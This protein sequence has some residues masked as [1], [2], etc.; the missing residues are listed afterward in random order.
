M[1]I[2]TTTL[3]RVATGMVACAFSLHAQAATCVIDAAANRQTIDGFGFSSAWSGTLSTAKNDALY[4]TL[5]FSLLRIRIDPNQNWSEETANSSAAHARGAKVMGSSWTPPASMK[6]NN[7]LVGGHLRTDQYGAYASWLNQAANSI[8]LDYVSFQNEPD[9]TVTY[10]S[11]SWTAA[12]LQTFVRNNA[13]TIG[14]SVIMPES[15][16]FNDA[17]SDPTLNDSVAVNNVAVVGG[18]IYGNGLFVH[19]NAINKGK[20]VWMTEHYIDNTQSSMANC[21]TIAKE[22][23]DCMN[24]QM[25]AYYWWWVTDSDTSIN[26]VNSSG[27][28]FKN[29]YTLGQFAKWIRPGSVRVAADYNPTSGIYVTAYKSNNN[30]IIVAINTSTGAV[31][32]QFS[33]SNGSVG[34]VT[35]YR[36]SSSQNLAQLG[37]IALSGN[38]FT[39]SLPGQSVT[40]FVQASTGGSGPV[41]DGTYKIVARHSGL[42][43]EVQGA[44]TANGSQIDQYTYFGNNHQRWTVTNRGNNQYSLIGVASGRGIDIANASTA[45]G[46]KVQLYD[47]WG[48]N[49]QKFTFTATSN[50]YYRITPVHATSSCLDVAG[51]STSPGALVHLWTYGGGNNQQWILQAP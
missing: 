15:F 25:N 24:A 10:D 6:D 17:Y 23:S 16:N 8:G 20:K 1:K 41:T 43:M 42:A 48:G 33:I 38:S 28:I 50:G 26:L 5:G 11:C 7:N 4:N 51:V 9:I 3:L 35:P 49:N 40:T 29:G 19:Q 27:T 13:P 44:A 36:T 34:S 47:Y 2:P 32:Q 21:M 18:H 22:V 14:R 30:V 46:T 12:Q 39:T 31:N 45:N 37:T